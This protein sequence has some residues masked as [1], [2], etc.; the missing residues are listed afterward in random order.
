MTTSFRISAL[1]SDQLDRIRSRGKDDFG[2]EL[3]VLTEQGD[4]GTPLRCC[5]RDAYRGERFLLI[6]W[7]PAEIG[8][9]Y[10]EVGPVFVHAEACGGYSES[11]SYPAGFRHRRQLFRA[12]DANGWQIDNRVV[13]GAEAES[14]VGNFFARDEVSYVHSRNLMAGCYMFAIHRTNCGPS[15]TDA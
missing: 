10:A 6:A 15:P 3:V 13:E 11:R 4:G 1:P 7:R 14:A 8:G 2:N 12:Y 9:P 5:L